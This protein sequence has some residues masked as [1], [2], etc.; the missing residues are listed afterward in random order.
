MDLR[1]QSLALMIVGILVVAISMLA[2]VIGIGANPVVIGWKQ[3]FGAAIGIMLILFGAH[4]TIHHVIGDR[5]GMG[6]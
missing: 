5:Q 3:Y 6:R 4:L 1:I 2:D